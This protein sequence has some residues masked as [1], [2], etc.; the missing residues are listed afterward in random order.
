MDSNS[1]FNDIMATRKVTLRRYVRTTLQTFTKREASIR[2]AM[3]YSYSNGALEGMNNKIK[4]NKRA[5]YGFSNFRRFKTKV[6]LTCEF[7]R[8][9]KERKRRLKEERQKRKQQKNQIRKRA[10]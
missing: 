5:G 8:I 2:A 6:F 10:S 4:N 9:R 3:D 7:H 1:F